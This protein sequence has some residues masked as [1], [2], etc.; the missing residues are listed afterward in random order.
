MPGA[1]APGSGRRPVRV[2][3]MPGGIPPLSNGTSMAWIRIVEPE[4]ADEALARLLDRA[5]P[6][7]RPDNILLAH[8]LRPHTLDGHLALYRAVLHHPANALDR[9][10]AEALGVLVSLVNGCRYCVVHHAEGVRR[11]LA[12]PAR[13]EAWLTALESGPRREVFDTRQRAALAYVEQLTREPA[14][15]AARDLQVLRDAG[16]DDGEILEIN[17][18]AAY[19]AYANRVVLGLGVEM[20]S[21]RR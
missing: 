19:F 15:L 1:R 5:A 12:D 20:E 18:I 7:R 6:G 14:A 10:F 16:W 2:F 9:A 11:A 17:Q 3:V 21:E 4:H 8:G 13:A